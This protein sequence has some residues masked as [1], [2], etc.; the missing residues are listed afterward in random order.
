MP[1]LIKLPAERV[2][3]L[4]LLSKARDLP[5]ADLIAEYVRDQ[6]AAGHIPSGVPG[7]VVKRAGKKV[8][9]DYGTFTQTD[10]AQWAQLFALALRYV[11]SRRENPVSQLAEVVS[12]AHQMGVSRQGTGVKI[13][14]DKHERVLAPSIAVD[15]AD[16]IERIATA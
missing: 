2:E 15:L 16:E 14:V 4:R 9:I 10:D 1:D 8:R 11:A 13:K 5:I 3:Q 12:G 6:V 7:I